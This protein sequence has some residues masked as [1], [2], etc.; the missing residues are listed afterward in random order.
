M[1][2]HLQISA[3]VTLTMLEIFAN[4][5]CVLEEMKATRVFAVETESASVLTLVR[6]IRHTL[7]VSVEISIVATYCST[8]LQCAHNMERVTVLT[9]VLVTLDL[10]AKIVS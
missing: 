6:A 5:L 10:Q 9:L 3:H 2:A 7:E 4:Y 8:I 1:H